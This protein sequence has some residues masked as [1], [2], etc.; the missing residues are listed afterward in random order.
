[1]M[2]TE[3]ASIWGQILLLI[4]DMPTNA[5]SRLNKEIEFTRQTDLVVDL[6]L[7][8]DDAFEFMEKYASSLHVRKG[9]YDMSLYFDAES[10]WLLPKVGKSQPK[11]PITLGMLEVA[12]K[13]GVWDSNKLYQCYINNAY[14]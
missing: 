9:D 14:A 3:Q 1:M 2:V 5:F 13:Q 11:M 4:K 10:L 12:A 6:G 7:V 8:G